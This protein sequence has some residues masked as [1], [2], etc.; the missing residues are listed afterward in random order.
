[1]G[2]GHSPSSNR[3]GFAKIVAFFLCPFCIVMPTP[4]GGRV[5][6]NFAREGRGVNWKCE[7]MMMGYDDEMNNFLHFYTM[8]F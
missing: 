5:G 4:G 3:Y 1:M 6:G 8:A 7:M 2:I